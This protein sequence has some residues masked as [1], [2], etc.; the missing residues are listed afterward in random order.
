MLENGF[1]PCKPNFPTNEFLK[2]QPDSL[3]KVLFVEGPWVKFL[4]I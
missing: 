1:V 3:K 2:S 4:P